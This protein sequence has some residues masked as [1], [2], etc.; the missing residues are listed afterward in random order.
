M[1]TKP[2]TFNFAG[3]VS[4]QQRAWFDDALARCRFPMD[5]GGVDIDVK[6]VDEPSC[7]GHN[8]YMCSHTSATGALIEIRTAADDPDAPFNQGLPNPAKQIKQF[9]Q[10]SVIHELGH[11]F[12]YAALGDGAAE[13]LASMFYRDVQGETATHG[14]VEDWNPLDRKWVDRIGEASA[15]FFKDVY[16]PSTERVYDNRTNWAMDE[17]QFSAWIDVV[18]S[19]ICPGGAT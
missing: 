15:E 10:E 13:Q 2:F 18:D 8:D 6:T 11:I 19:I 14:T 7:P 1:P 16:L 12:F 5:R 17:D 3:S 4:G 9:F